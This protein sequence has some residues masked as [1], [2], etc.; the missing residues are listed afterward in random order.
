MDFII[1]F[2]HSPWHHYDGNHFSLDMQKKK[3]KKKIYISNR[4]KKTWCNMKKK[5]H[6]IHIQHTD[7]TP[8]PYHTHTKKKFTW[9]IIFILNK[10]LDQMSNLRIDL[11]ISTTCWVVNMKRI[12]KKEKT[13]VVQCITKGKTTI[14]FF[15]TLL[16]L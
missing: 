15:D 14:L 3:N 8:S 11:N 13:F 4:L 12:K 16:L 9:D 5:L 2:I 1:Y 10:F 7:N 6:S